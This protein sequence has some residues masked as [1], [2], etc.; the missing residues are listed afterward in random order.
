MSDGLVFST[1]EA[2]VSEALEEV[3]KK[4]EALETAITHI[5]IAFKNAAATNQLGWLRDMIN[6]E[7]NTT[8]SVQVNNAS[9]TLKNFATDLKESV[10]I[11]DAVSEG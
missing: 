8:G 7:W 4:N 6:N 10:T 5:T 2:G 9:T 3:K 1:S 11:S